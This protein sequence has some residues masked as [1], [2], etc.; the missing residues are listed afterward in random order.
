MHEISKETSDALT[1]ALTMLADEVL[2]NSGGEAA[3]IDIRV[4]APK[5]GPAM[6]A[7]GIQVIGCRHHD[8]EHGGAGDR[9]EDRP[10]YGQPADLVAELLRQLKR[11]GGN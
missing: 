8:H 7:L 1:K 10:V 3:L 6:I 2:A 4:G 11:K 5:H 9:R